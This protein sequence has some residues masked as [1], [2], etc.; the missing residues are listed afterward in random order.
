[1]KTIIAVA[2]AI[3]FA[4]GCSWADIV[5]GPVNNPANGHDYYLLTPSSWS[6]AEAEAEDLGGTLAVIH[7]A[8]EQ[9]WIFSRFGHY[10]GEER[11]LWIGLH[12]K[13]AGGPF[14]WVNNDPVNY[15]NWY[16]GEPN[17]VN[18]LEDCA[19]IRADAPLPGTW[20][21]L[22]EPRAIWSVVEV[23]GDLPITKN[24]RELVGDW[25]A[26]G[27][28][29][30]LCHIAETKDALFAVT[31]SNSGGQIVFDKKGFLFVPA[32]RCH[33]QVIADKILWSNGTWWSR[34][35]SPFAD[36]TRHGFNGVFIPD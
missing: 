32:W 4:A 22:D 1:M 36:G 14:V 33:G 5:V 3:L 26:G 12:R 7:D 6:N 13:V 35:P 23:T 31:D 16:I 15:T 8:G 17:N 24:E 21:D 25:Y 18:N 11:H 2:V 28:A 29:D 27:R 20:N 10:G 9:D 19:V 30:R 34:T